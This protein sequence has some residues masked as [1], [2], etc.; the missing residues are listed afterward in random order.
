MRWS[1]VVVLLLVLAEPALATEHRNAGGLH[2]GA[3]YRCTSLG[4]CDSVLVFVEA[5]NESPE[6]AN[7]CYVVGLTWIYVP[8]DSLRAAFAARM[9]STVK[10][11]G[12]VCRWHP[13]SFRLGPDEPGGLFPCRERSL[14]AGQSFTDTLVVHT[15]AREFVNYPGTLEAKVTL[16]SGTAGSTWDSAVV[17]GSCRLAIRVPK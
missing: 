15:G 11:G 17:A 6:P 7:G 14:D 3:S 16:W 8:A 13:V 1:S 4:P 2:V 5:T 12:Q 9:D 10:A